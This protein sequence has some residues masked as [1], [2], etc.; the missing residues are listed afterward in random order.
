[1]AETFGSSINSGGGRGSGGTGPGAA[2]QT[3]TVL[4]A[5]DTTL[6]AETSYNGSGNP[7]YDQAHVPDMFTGTTCLAKTPSIVTAAVDSTKFDDSENSVAPSSNI[8]MESIRKLFPRLATHGAAGAKIRMHLNPWWNLVGNPDH[9]NIGIDCNTT[10]WVELCVDVLMAQGYD[11]VTIDWYGE[12]SFIDNVTK[13]I[14]DYIVT[15]SLAF[16]Y[17]VMIDKGAIGGTGATATA[18]LVSAINYINTTHFA[19]TK[20]AKWGSQPILMFFGVKDIS[21]IDMTYAKSSTSGTNAYW[22]DQGH[23]AMAHARNNACYSWTLPWTDGEANH[24]SDPYNLQYHNDFTWNM[25]NTYPTAKH[26]LSADPHFNGTKTDDVNWSKGKRKRHDWGRHWIETC[27]Y[28]NSKITANTIMVQVIG[29]NDYEEGTALE[30]G[31]RNGITVTPSIVGTSVQW[32]LS[33]GM[34]DNF[35]ETIDHFEVLVSINDSDYSA[36][37]RNTAKTETTFD[38]VPFGHRFAAGTTYKVRVRAVGVC[39]VHNK[40]SAAVNYTH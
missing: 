5:A 1:M 27:A 25:L 22:M 31:I 6:A 23:G 24:A 39:H 29:L 10:A 2:A 7:D 15:N 21:G 38:L 17:A 26:A 40:T 4:L 14:R 18:N 20:Y 34:G 16:D 33:G 30:N 35:T 32:S 9:P 8:S 37:S 28:V 19:S 11:G 13:K 12:G 36:L 3:P